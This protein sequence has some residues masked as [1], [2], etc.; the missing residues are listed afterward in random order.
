MGML[1][2]GTKVNSSAIP[3]CVQG[4][5]FTSVF[6]PAIII[7]VFSLSCSNSLSNLFGDGLI[8]TEGDLS[9][10]DQKSGVIQASPGIEKTPGNGDALVIPADKSLMRIK[11][12]D[13][14]VP[15]AETNGLIHFVLEY[16]LPGALIMDRRTP[17]PDS[18]TLYVDTI[19]VKR[20][21]VAAQGE[22]EN[23]GAELK[24]RPAGRDATV[25]IA[26]GRHYIPFVKNLS[27]PAGRYKDLEVEF[28]RRGTIRY[29][30][31]EFPLEIK[32]EE[33]KFNQA[34]ESVA[35]KI[36]ILHS[37]PARE[38][39]LKEGDK[40]KPGWDKESHHSIE[41]PDEAHERNERE[42]YHAHIKVKSNG[43]SV[44][45]PVDQ[46]FINMVRLEAV[47]ASGNRFLLN[48]TPTRF[49]LLQLRDGAVG[50][51]GHN[52][53]PKG[54]YAY[55][56]LTIGTGNSVVVSG[57]S[58]P[59]AIEYQTQD[60][61]RFE[62]P[63]DLRGGRIT[64]LFLHFDPNM[65][66]FY[67]KNYGY[68][69][70]PSI[71]AL[72]VISMTADQDLRFIEALGQRSNIVASESEVIFQ[73]SVSRLDTILAN[74]MYGKRMIYSDMDLSV[75]DR[76]RGDVA[77][78]RPFPLMVIGGSYGGLRLRA[79]GMPEFS[80]GKRYL[81]FLRKY[82]GRYGVVRGEW[83]KVEL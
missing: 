21:G 11:L 64:E 13:D 61:L 68:I 15:N 37:I 82:N 42:R 80:Q 63:F 18:I 70:D 83:G 3:R 44:R 6:V 66:L 8:L 77:I 33:V 2:N 1:E 28:K 50:L 65:S 57:E 26:R 49:E 75:E 24:F 30:K 31:V 25:E 19:E 41:H 22:D 7:L 38:S 12:F 17:E 58:D 48:D 56:E 9:A 59:I 4:I 14:P 47:D 79:T 43:Y 69:L 34:F 54:E 76:L 29:G 73:G 20:L 62:G 72:S 45:P 35:G 51:M 78:D 67:T 40:K 81:L 10:H 46:I 27:L 16:E 36:T 32:T 23:D 74:N 53:L 52:M 5:Q 60:R 39:A 71:A 55:F